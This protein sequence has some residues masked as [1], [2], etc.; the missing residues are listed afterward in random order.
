MQRL[1]RCRIFAA[2]LGASTLTIASAVDRGSSA[3]TLLSRK[4]VARLQERPA[5][6]RTRACHPLGERRPPRGSDRPE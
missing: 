5:I 4:D 2:N 6:D 1:R 3:G